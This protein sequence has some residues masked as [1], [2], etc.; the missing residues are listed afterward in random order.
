[1]SKNLPISYS[2]NDKM[3]AAKLI[4]EKCEAIQSGAF[5]LLLVK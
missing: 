2:D 1:M 5:K 3:A 4:L